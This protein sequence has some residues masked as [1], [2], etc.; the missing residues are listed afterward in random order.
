ML[1]REVVAAAGA[2][3]EGTVGVAQ[4]NCL[5]DYLSDAFPRVEGR[6]LAWSHRFPLLVREITALLSLGMIV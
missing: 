1:G 6:V 5:A 4:F 3:A 2:T